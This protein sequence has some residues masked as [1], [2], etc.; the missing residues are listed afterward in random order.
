VRTFGKYRLVELLASGG[1]A[2]VW[3][4]EVAGAAGVV[5]E[6]ALKRVRGEHGARSD[7][8]RMFIEEARLAS[9]LTHANVVQVFE[10]DQ[11]DGRYYIAMELV[12]GR[13][14]GQVVERAREVG[15]RLGLARAVHA[16]AE[17]A[18][19]LSYAHRLADGG[20]PLGLVHRDVSPH[21]VLVSFEGEV[22]LA[23]FGI[24]R[25]AEDDTGLTSS[26][27]A[28]GSMSY[29][30]PEQLMGHPTDGRA[31]QYSLAATAYRLFTGSPPF[32]HSNP[33]VIISH[34]LNTP[35]PRLGDTR[36]ELRAFDAAMTRALAKDP[37]ARFGSCHG[38]AEALAQA[39]GSLA[40]PPAPATAPPAPVGPPPG[41]SFP[42][43]PIW[44]PPSQP[45]AGPPVLVSPWMPSG[46]PYP[47][48]QYGLAQR[49]PPRRPRGL[50]VA[51][52]VLAVILLVAAVVSVV[53]VSG[54]D[55]DST[56][57]PETTTTMRSRTATTTALPT[58]TS[59]RPN[60]SVYTI[61]DYI[62][63]NRI[64]EV[65]IGRERDGRPRATWQK[66]AVV[67]SPDGLFIL[68]VNGYAPA[69]ERRL[70]TDVGAVIDQRTTVAS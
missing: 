26:N 30:A 33:A 38:F 20:R 7:F 50:T 59:V 29:S 42:G 66:T 3:R 14:L 5:K 56:P 17:V 10:F 48:A 1:M 36:P 2:D 31:D 60:R 32:P 27:I 41:L 62:R 57:N 39:T 21:N 61:A 58:A 34:H 46:A 45:H 44:A 52:A 16:C 47:G 55:D 63:D 43:P 53:A 54:S 40:A 19:G 8:V 23:D 12:R 69:A 49:Q 15:V 67:D 68:Q 11:V 24:A 28:V 25:H 37:A 51:G 13:H 18:R 65:P 70:I 35:P 9:R 64:V 6:V 4:A 22:K